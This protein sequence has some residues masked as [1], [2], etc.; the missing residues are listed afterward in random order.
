MLLN[1][2]LKILLKKVKQEEEQKMG[3]RRFF[4]RLHQDL[5]TRR[6]R[7]FF[8]LSDAWEF[9]ALNSVTCIFLMVGSSTLWTWCN[10]AP[11]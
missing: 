5:W 9:K 3:K 11:Q 8:I 1:I 7:F 2:L 6:L 4:R 10:Y